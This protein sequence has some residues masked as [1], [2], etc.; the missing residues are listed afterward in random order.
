MHLWVFFGK[1]FWGIFTMHVYQNHAEQAVF[2]FRTPDNYYKPHYN[3]LVPHIHLLKNDKN[4]F[5]MGNFW[6][7]WGFLMVR[8]LPI[9]V[10]RVY[11]FGLHMKTTII[12]RIISF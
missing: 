2:G 11:F 10:R 6:H 4:H 7:F 5:F 9:W 3:L 1:I 12:N 8:L